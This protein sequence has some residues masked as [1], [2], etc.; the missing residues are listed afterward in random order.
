ME[1]GGVEGR[2]CGGGV[3]C[4]KSKVAPKII[5]ELSL[6]SLRH[7]ISTKKIKVFIFAKS[8]VMTKKRTYAIC[9]VVKKIYLTTQ[10]N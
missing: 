3:V 7:N 10:Q 9:T 6:S 2:R 4:K 8:Y 1:G 5:S